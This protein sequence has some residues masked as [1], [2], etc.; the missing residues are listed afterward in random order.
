MRRP[1]LP[2][3]SLSCK[4]YAYI[5]LLWPYAFDCPFMILF[6]IE[7]CVLVLSFFTS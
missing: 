3:T 7:V 1:G 4:Q 2:E 6:D 5:F